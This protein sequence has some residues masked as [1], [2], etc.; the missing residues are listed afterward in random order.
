[1]Q[2]LLS[3]FTTAVILCSLTLTPVLAADAGKESGMHGNGS[4][5]QDGLKDD[6]MQPA[7]GMME[8]N[9]MKP[10]SSMMKDSGMMQDGT[11]KDDGMKKNNN[12]AKM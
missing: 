8:D 9:G 12:P 7:S 4:A 10:A 5:M 2:K 11:M 1:M 3:I 6:H